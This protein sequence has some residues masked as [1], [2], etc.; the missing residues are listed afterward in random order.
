MDDFHKWLKDQKIE[1]DEAQY[2]KEY[3]MIR[4]RVQGDIYVTAFNLDE[5]NKYEL[6][7]DPE[8]LAAVAALPKSQALLDSSTKARERA[9]K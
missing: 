7:T 3:E 8:V 4:R 6:A 9:Q 1:F 2:T 5:S